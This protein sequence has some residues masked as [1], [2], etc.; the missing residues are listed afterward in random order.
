MKSFCLDLCNF[1]DTNLDGLLK[2]VFPLVNNERD[3]EMASRGLILVA[4]NMVCVH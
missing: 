4:K 1:I 2:G 3:N